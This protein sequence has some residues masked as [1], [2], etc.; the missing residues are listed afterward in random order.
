MATISA[1][2]GP[3]E[4]DKMV[5]IGYQAIIRKK[6]HP[7]QTRTFRTKRDAERWARQV[8]SEMDRGVF[9]QRTESEQ[10]TYMDASM[11]A[12]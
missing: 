7:S 1:R 2:K 10:T 8:E 3:D 5:V 11:C 6:G 12:R 4:N 9:V